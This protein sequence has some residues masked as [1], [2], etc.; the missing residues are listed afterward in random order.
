MMV[1]SVSMLPSW[2]EGGGV[3]PKRETIESATGAPV[4]LSPQSPRG[5][6]DRRYRTQRWKRARLRVLNRDNWTCRVVEDCPARANV[7]DH[8][9]PVSPTMPDSLFFGLSNLRAACRDHNLAR[10]FAERL[11][12]EPVKGTAVITRDYSR[13]E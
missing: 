4:S 6:T 12:A 13:S 10:G 1:R 8:V 2:V 11:S 9:I 5:I 7:A 3:A